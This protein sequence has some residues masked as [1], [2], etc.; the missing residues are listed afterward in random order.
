MQAKTDVKMLT[1]KV[2]ILSAA[3]QAAVAFLIAAMLLWYFKTPFLYV[4]PAALGIFFLMHHALKLRE[5]RLL[6]CSAIMA[7]LVA[8]SFILGGKVNVLQKHF[9]AFRKMDVVCFAGMAIV[10]VTLLVL[11]LSCRQQWK[12]FLPMA[13]AIMIFVPVVQGTM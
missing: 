8:V 11:L 3:E 4:M 12:K 9:E 1:G 5:K 6:L 10:V 7:V 13:L 2:Q